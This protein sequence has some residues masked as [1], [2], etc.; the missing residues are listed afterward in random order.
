MKTPQAPSGA[1]SGYASL[2]NRPDQAG[3]ILIP[4]AFTRALAQRGAGGVRMLFQ[5]DPSRPIGVWR[6][7]REDARGLF[8]RGQ[9]TPGVAQ[10][11]EL[12]ALLQ[13]GA[14]DGLSIGFK[15]RRARHER[16]S[17]RRYL[18]EVDLWEIS[19]VTFPMLPGARVHALKGCSLP[20]VNAPT[21]T[22]K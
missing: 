4:G 19:L 14:L 10:A 22:S 3:D 12:G 11:R 6:E 16:T 8:V 7:L 17:G 21:A 2:F 5:H 13:A 20:P 9:L 1:F 18:L 15:T